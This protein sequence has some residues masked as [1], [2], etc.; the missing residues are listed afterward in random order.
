[1]KK[2]K[3]KTTKVIDFFLVSFSKDIFVLLLILTFQL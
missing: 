1:M 3:P 2:A